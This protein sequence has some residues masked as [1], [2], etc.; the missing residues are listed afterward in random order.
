MVRS[1]EYRVKPIPSKSEL[2]VS[3]SNNLGV[4]RSK[5]LAI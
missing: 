5:N 3:V 1:L 2:K 4:Q